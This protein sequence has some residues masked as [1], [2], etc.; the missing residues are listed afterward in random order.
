MSVSIVCGLQAGDEAKGRITAHLMDKA[1]MCVRY[2]GSC[3][4]G[5]TVYTA[6]GQKFKFHHLPV[7]IANNKPSYIGAACLIDPRRLAE[8]IAQYKA[9]GFDVDANLRIS[10]DAHIITEDHI[11]RD[12]AAEDQGNGVGSTRRGVSPCASDKYA[13]KGM[14]M[15]TLMEFERYF[16]DVPYELNHAID[17]GKHVVFEGSQGFALDVDQGNYPFVSTTS[18]VS[19]AACS[20]CG[21]GPNRIT[22]VIGVA[23]CYSTYVG[24]GPYPTEI[25]DAELNERIAITGHE[26]GTTTG[27]R[28]RVGFV[29]LPMLKRSCMVNGCTSIALT[30]SDVLKGMRA[31]VC[32]AYELDGKV[33]DR[34][35]MLKSDYWRVKPVYEELDVVTGREFIP[36]VE[37][38]T[39]LRV[40]YW[41]YGPDRNQIEEL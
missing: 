40:R 23:K 38:A 39:G 26:Y 31:K 25:K 1:D 22:E 14:R 37:A 11:R 28:R 34:V 13:R 35:P 8:E 5:A 3:N 33:I 29:D 30:K 21:V 4:T 9:Y 16:A 36:I 6:A 15:E 2:S 12:C 24:T 10:P 18:N 41:S 7:S 32:V 17:D 20:S 19:G 27:R